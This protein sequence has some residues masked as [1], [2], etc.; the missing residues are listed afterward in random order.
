LIIYNFEL[1]VAHSVLKITAYMFC[2]TD[3]LLMASED[4][5][6]FNKCVKLDNL[7]DLAAA[8][9][10]YDDL[11]KAP[12][13]LN[14]TFYHYW[15]NMHAFI[16]ESMLHFNT[17][18][19]L[20]KANSSLISIRK[21][22][23]VGVRFWMSP[24]INK[25]TDKPH[26]DMYIAR[27]AIALECRVTEQQVQFWKDSAFGKLRFDFLQL[28]TKH[29]RNPKEP[30]FFLDGLEISKKDIKN[31]DRK[32]YSEVLDLESDNKKERKEMDRFLKLTED[33]TNH[34]FIKGD[35]LQELIAENK[36]D[37]TILERLE[38]FSKVLIIIN[39]SCNTDM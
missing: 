28:L 35:K 31:F 21:A 37:D 13:N 29:S 27:C 2:N 39:I 18:E 34:P 8:F 10:K 16:T 11:K 23:D 9:P 12:L 38:F 19:K 14:A 25:N 17:Y 36:L 22:A 26:R 1:C 33:I 6:E 20:V 4:V 3:L 30:F 15:P 24:S 5:Q 7:K 32:E